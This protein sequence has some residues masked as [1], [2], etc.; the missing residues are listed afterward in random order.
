MKIQIKLEY[1]YP[2]KPYQ[3]DLTFVGK[4]KSLLWRVAT[5]RLKLYIK[6]LIG[7][8]SLA[9]DKLSSLLC[10]FISIE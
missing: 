6:Y 1:L 3:P 10:H 4:A 8:E 2:A 9:R 5:G 7:L